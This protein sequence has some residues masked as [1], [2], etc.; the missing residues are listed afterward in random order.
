MKSEIIPIQYLRG[1][2]ALLVVSVHSIEQQ[3]WLK[4]MFPFTF[5]HSGVDLFFVISG[6]IMVYSTHN[7]NISSKAFIANRLK[8]IAPLYWFFTSALILVATIAPN[9]VRSFE[10]DLT[11]ILSSYF[12]LAYPSPVSSYFW[13]VLIPGWSLNYEMLFY[14]AFAMS[15]FLRRAYQ[16]PFMAAILVIPVFF[17]ISATPSSPLS[18]YTSPIILEF[19][20]GIILG[21]LF[22]NGQIS[23]GNTKGIIV[24]TLGIFYYLT[25]TINFEF[26]RAFSAGIASSI[27][28]YGALAIKIEN[29]STAKHQLLHLL[30]DASYSI[31]LSHVFTLGIL[32][33]ILNIIQ[34]EPSLSSGILI[35]T[36]ALITSSL[37]GIISF[38]FI[39]RPLIRIFK[40]K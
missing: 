32:R 6:F 13:P 1:V 11:H 9:V 40:K 3:S 21:H 19:F 26:N 10:F 18:F 28:L 25:T 14:V 20:F 29:I 33:F 5:G 27:I 23:K 4:D 17:H 7:R 2:A 12:F 8:R 37:I 38:F 35:I 39:E 22:I 34:P 30:G 15:L 36:C 31:Y 24:I 16:L